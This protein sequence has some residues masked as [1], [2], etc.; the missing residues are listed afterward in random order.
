MFR[1]GVDVGGT[2]TDG[3]ILDL[4]PGVANPIIA[5]AKSPTTKDVNLGIE[6]TISAVLGKSQAD[7]KQI[8]AV[9]I[10]TTHFVNALIQRSEANLAR[11]AV[12]R[13]CGPFTRDCPP[14]SG[15]PYAIREIL[16]GPVFMVEGG[17]QLDGTLISEVGVLIDT[18]ADLRYKKRR[19]STLAQRSKARASSASPSVA[20]SHP[21]TLPFDKSRR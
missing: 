17:L 14:F 20:S 21:S 9:C 10:G 3:V 8:Q 7:R 2:N 18:L 16:E 11:V 15:F 1:I 6:N 5:A 12:I 13:L 4:S 19:S